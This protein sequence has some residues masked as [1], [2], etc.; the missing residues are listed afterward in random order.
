MPGLGPEMST[1]RVNGSVEIDE[2]T[3]DRVIVT[4]RAG[5]AERRKRGIRLNH[6]MI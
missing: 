3:L 2:G 1:L 6:L 5:V 4:A